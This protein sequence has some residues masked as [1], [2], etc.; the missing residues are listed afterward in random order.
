[1]AHTTN[2]KY[3]CCHMSFIKI[4]QNNFSKR[5]TRG[6]TLCILWRKGTLTVSDILE[7][8]FNDETV[9][10]KDNKRITRMIQTQ[11]SWIRNKSQ[12]G[13]R[14]IYITKLGKVYP[15][16]WRIPGLTFP[17]KR[18]VSGRLDCISIPTVFRLSKKTI[19]KNGVFSKSVVIDSREHKVLWSIILTVVEYLRDQVCSPNNELTNISNWFAEEL[20]NFYYKSV[21]TVVLN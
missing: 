3:I 9:E 7:T 18:I 21:F 15:R 8:F 6:Y 1:M 19:C 11:Q 12:G 2:H 20:Y 4:L 5:K 13:S 16:Q 17:V 10:G 14:K